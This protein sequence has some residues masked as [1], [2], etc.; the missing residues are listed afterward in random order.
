MSVS[1]ING[2]DDEVVE[3]TNTPKK[4]IKHGYEPHKLISTVYYTCPNCNSH[5]SRTKSCLTCGQ[6]LD[7]SDTE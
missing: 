7:W 1:L 4:P 5:I 6:A 3:N 2:H